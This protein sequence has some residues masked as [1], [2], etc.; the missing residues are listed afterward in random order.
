[1]VTGKVLPPLSAVL[2]APKLPLVT[3]QYWDVRSRGFVVDGKIL[4]FEQL[5]ELT[6]V[7]DSGVYAGMD[8]V[9]I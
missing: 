4:N 8:C 7:L 9:V 6:F 1:M 3:A 5:N 2:S